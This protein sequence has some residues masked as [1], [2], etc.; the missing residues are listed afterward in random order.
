[1]ISLTPY[2]SAKEGSFLPASVK[3][4]TGAVPPVSIPNS[5]PTSKPNWSTLV[6]LLQVLL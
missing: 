6:V 5:F 2:F 1:V 4:P 3:N